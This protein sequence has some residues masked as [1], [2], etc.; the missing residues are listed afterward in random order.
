MSDGGCV[1]RI[2]RLLVVALVIG[3]MLVVGCS[4]RNPMNDRARDIDR[5]GQLP[6][7]P[8]GGTPADE[9][10]DVELGPTDP[11]ELVM[12]TISL[13]LPREQ[14]MRSFLV[15]LYNPRSPDYRKFL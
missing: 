10:P 9:Q 12:F 8:T 1:P 15:D 4:A 7:D 13:V 11:A 6:L 2:P 5:T 3:V 14:E